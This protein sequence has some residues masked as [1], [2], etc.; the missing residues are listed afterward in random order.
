MQCV[1][2][3]TLQLRWGAQGARIL[4]RPLRPWARACAVPGPV[5]QQVLVPLGTTYSIITRVANYA[6][7]ATHVII[8]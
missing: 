2:V 4:E 7:A 8:R 5:R 1:V 6:N 3:G